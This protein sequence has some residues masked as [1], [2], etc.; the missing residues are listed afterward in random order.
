MKEKYME[1]S[2]AGRVKRGRGQVQA[3]IENTYL[4]LLLASISLKVH[5]VKCK[6]FVLITYFLSK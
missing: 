1:V 4:V 6:N 2:V 5:C 3:K